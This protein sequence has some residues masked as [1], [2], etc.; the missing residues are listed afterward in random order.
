MTRNRCP[1]RPVH[2]DGTECTHK[3]RPS[4]KPLDPGC[5][6]RAGYEATCS[7]G[8]KLGHSNIR[9]ALEERRAAHLNTHKSRRTEPEPTVDSAEDYAT[10]R[11]RDE[12][13]GL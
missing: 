7:C 3:I 12:R 2:A 10:E 11:S 8:V 5:P 1:I 4:G 13:M 6:G 9:A